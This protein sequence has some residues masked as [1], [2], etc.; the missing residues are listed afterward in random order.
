MTMATAGN[1]FQVTGTLTT[2]IDGQLYRRPP[3]AT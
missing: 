1:D 2:T 3:N